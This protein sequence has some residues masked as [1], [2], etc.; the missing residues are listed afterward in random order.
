MDIVP[1]PGQFCWLEL[2]T[3]D[4]DAARAFYGRL[5]G[6]TFTEAPV[7]DGAYV[8]ASLGGR[9][10]AG[11]QDLGALPAGVPPHWLS[12]ISV[13]DADDAAEACTA[14]KGRV[15]KAP[16]DLMDAGRMA[17]LED[18][19]G[20]VFAVWEPHA[21]AGFGVRGEPGA[22]AW[23]ELSTPDGNAAREFYRMLFG[24]TPEDM[25][26]PTGAYVICHKGGRP[27]AGLMD[28]PDRKG[29]PP[30]W[31]PHFQV[32]DCEAAA[33]VAAAAGGRVEHPP[34]LVPVGTFAII[35]DP[36]GAAFA[37]FERAAPHAPRRR[38]T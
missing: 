9:P 20:G 8:V 24:W 11:L 29:V 7:P 4:T 32:E 19:T 36:A 35:A 38:P 14:L 25:P 2:A 18:P 3:P 13:V 17:V 28:A 21:F 37:L 22:L 27:E 16:F 10:M 12:Y 30:H 34:T 26:V 5:F 15:L 33:R 6:W 23:P 31:L 1:G